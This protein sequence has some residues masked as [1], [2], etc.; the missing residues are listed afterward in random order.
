MPRYDYACPKCG[1][2]REIEHGY[3]EVAVEECEVCGTAL[4]RSYHGQMVGVTYKG[5]GFYHVESR[6][7][8]ERRKN[9]EI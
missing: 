5:R 1:T 8:K 7:E 3:K 6:I 4:V 2:V 9:G